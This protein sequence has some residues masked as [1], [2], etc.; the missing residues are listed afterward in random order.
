MQSHRQSQV[1]IVF[2]RLGTFICVHETCTYI[3]FSH[4]ISYVILSRPM[5]RR[6]RLEV[7]P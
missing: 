7:F 6:V 1:N 4:I 2:I 3:E 5:S